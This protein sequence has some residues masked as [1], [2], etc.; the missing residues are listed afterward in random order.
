MVNR[1]C[2][3]LRTTTGSF[4]S[5]IVTTCTHTIEDTQGI[6]VCFG[7]VDDP[8]L[9]EEAKHALRDDDEI[10]F[11][12]GCRYTLRDQDAFCPA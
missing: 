6:S 8:N 7:T 3:V 12:Q 4:P 11:G 2:V 9:L 10:Y 5:N 1:V